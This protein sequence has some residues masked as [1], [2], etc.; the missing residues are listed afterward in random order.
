MEQVG[1]NEYGH[2]P[3]EQVGRSF[4]TMS[5]YPRT[6]GYKCLMFL[7]YSPHHVE[8]LGGGRVRISNRAVTYRL[9]TA[10]QKFRHSMRKFAEMG[11]VSDIVETKHHTEVTLRRPDL[12]TWG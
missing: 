1:A 12:S 8:R 6:G 2:Q 4:E 3:S 9:H 5:K 10:P 7:L 11:Y